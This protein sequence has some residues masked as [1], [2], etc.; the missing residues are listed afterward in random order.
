MPMPEELFDAIGFSQ[1]F[2]TLDLRSDYYQLL[3]LLGDQSKTTFQGVDQDSKDQLYCW[4]FFPFGL[5]NAPT[6][7][8]RVM[9][10]VLASLPFARCYIDEVIIFNSRSTRSC[11]TFASS[12]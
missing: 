12:I 11:E 9:D 5:K 4:K 3:L 6:E 1:V 10:Q 7:F 2:S 8:Q